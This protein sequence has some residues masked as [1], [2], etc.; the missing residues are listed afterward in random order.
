M[1]TVYIQDSIA[2]S[3]PN[4]IGTFCSERAAR[5]ALRD[6]LGVRRLSSKTPAFQDNAICAGYTGTYEDDGEFG[7]VE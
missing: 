6:A 2:G 7:W 5:K 1:Y 3:Q 4:Q